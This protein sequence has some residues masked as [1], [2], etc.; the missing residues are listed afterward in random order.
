M[1]KH[2]HS[3]DSTSEPRVYTHP[4]GRDENPCAHGGIEVTDECACGARRLRLIN[5][6]HEECGD[7]GPSRATREGRAS[8]LMAKAQIAIGAVRPITVTHR[9]GRTVRISVDSE[10]F[11]CCDLPADE[12]A[13]AVQSAP[14]FLAAAQ[15]A[16]RAVLAARDAR[17]DV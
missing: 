5:G 2:T 3:V 14:V 13:R 7:W 16:R 12:A 8:E 4:V 15:A 17:A 10:G 11:I 9:D 6:A 1:A